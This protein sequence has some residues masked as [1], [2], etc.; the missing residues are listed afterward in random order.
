MQHG[1]RYRKKGR[2]AGV[3]RAQKKGPMRPARCSGPPPGQS[4]LGGACRQRGRQ[5]HRGGKNALPRP[6]HRRGQRAPARLPGTAQ[7]ERER[8]I[9]GIEKAEGAQHA[10]GSSA[11]VRTGALAVRADRKR[12]GLAK[13]AARGAVPWRVQ[14]GCAGRTPEPAAILAAAGTLSA[15]PPARALRQAAQGRSGRPKRPA[16]GP[17]SAGAGR[18][19]TG[20]TYEVRSP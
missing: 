9:L 5:R 19:R 14:A 16:K 1:S 7:A 12:D 4:R 11:A 3:R 15:M 2:H 18:S 6:G 10:K 17:G 20:E 8:R 13:E